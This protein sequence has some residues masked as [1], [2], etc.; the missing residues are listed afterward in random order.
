MSNEVIK[1]I[2][3]YEAA[4]RD[5]DAQI[6][7]AQGDQLELLRAHRAWNLRIVAGLRTL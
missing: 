4:I 1:M 3:D 7:F 6:P 2:R 5:Y